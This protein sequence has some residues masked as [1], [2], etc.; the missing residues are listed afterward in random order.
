MIVVNNR[1]P[2]N[3]AHAEAFE[4]V[5]SQRA[6]LVDG[7]DGFIAFRLLRP[8]KPEDPYV[9][10]T[11]WESMAQYQAW[12]DSEAFK[13]GHA[14]SGTLPKETFTGHP[15]LELFEV[16]QATGDSDPLAE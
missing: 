13:Q 6:G 7:M 12:I 14:Q 10:M 8:Q 1:I 2:V 9:V 5:F 16:I 15:T 11:F 4:R 3:P